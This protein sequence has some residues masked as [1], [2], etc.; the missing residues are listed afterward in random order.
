[1]PP[2]NGLGIKGLAYSINMPCLRHS[3]YIPNAF[4]VRT[5]SSPVELRGP[6]KQTPSRDSNRKPSLQLSPQPGAGHFPI[7]LD[8]SV[9]DAEDFRHFFNGKAAKKFEFDDPALL[10]IDSGQ[11]F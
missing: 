8:C 6:W 10:R 1:M 2:I 4:D 11:F 5:Q 3:E 7:A 9:A